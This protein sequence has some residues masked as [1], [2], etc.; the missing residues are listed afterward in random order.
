MSKFC[1]FD[2]VWKLHL[3]VKWEEGGSYS[4][5]MT[6]ISFHN[7]LIISSNFSF[8]H[9]SPPLSNFHYFC[10][11]TSSWSSGEYLKVFP[12]LILLAR[13]MN[14]SLPFFPIKISICFCILRSSH[15]QVDIWWMFFLRPP[16]PSLAPGPG[17]ENTYLLD[18]WF[19]FHII[20]FIYFFFL[21]AFLS[22]SHCEKLIRMKNEKQ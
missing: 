14:P 6:H 2:S 18:L 3:L 12:A 5:P 4:T 22:F 1:C 15:H 19:F 8:Y 21:R 11:S 10:I 20:F 7:F 17:F 9:L 13:G 16:P